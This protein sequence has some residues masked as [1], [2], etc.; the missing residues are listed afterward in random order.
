MPRKERTVPQPGA[1]LASARNYTTNRSAE[2]IDR[3]RGRTAEEW[4]H[5]AWDFFD[6][7][8]EYHQ[9]CMAIGALLS[10][11]KLVVEERDADG[12]WR[13]TENAAVLQVHNELYGG[14]E[15]QAEMLR[16]F[17][18]HFAVTG[19]GWLIAESNATTPDQWMVASP[20]AVRKGAGNAWRVNDEDLTGTPLVIRIWRAHS[21][22]RK[23]A[24][25]PTRA[26]LP[27]L[28]ELL[29][30]TKRVAAQIDSRLLGG[31][32][33]LLP[34][35]TSFGVA[36]QKALNVGDPVTGGTDSIA[37]GDAQ[38]LAD[39][40]VEQANRA[41]ANPEDP[42][43]V[44]PIIGETPGEFIDKAR[45]LT[46]WSELDKTAPK[47]RAESIQRIAN[48]MDIPPEVLLGAQGSN[49]WNAWLSD[50]VSVKIHAEPTL[51]TIVTSLSSGYLRPALT[52][53]VD[54]PTRF[55]YAAD[56][57]Q[58][59][60]RPNRSKEAL[61]LNDRLILSDA[62][63]ARENGFEPADLMTDE[64]K[65]QK[66]IGLAA[67]GSTTP[68]IVAAAMK[69]LG[70]DLGIQITDQR[71]PAQARPNRSLDEHPVREIPAA[72]TGNSPDSGTGRGDTGNKQLPA[73]ANAAALGLLF[74]SEQIVDR[75]LQ[76]AG[77]R[78]KTQM[79][80]QQRKEV[81][82][83]ANRLYCSAHI[84]PEDVPDLLSDA[85]GACHEYDYGVSGAALERVLSLYTRSLLTSGAEPT[86]RGLA[87][88]LSLLP[89][90]PGA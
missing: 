73:A 80:L 30:L 57:A 15:G 1:I 87:V 45:H 49:H 70:I 40:L 66:V 88:A 78:L 38:G 26:I 82:T 31:G 32:L 72:P 60:L 79:P 10:R 85:W 8:P 81:T 25:S 16:Q 27:V 76:R 90:L 75:A 55:R 17:G 20:I 56:T 64:E 54:D 36:P 74:A 48:G 35:E 65:A 21:L 2:K 42:S 9:G 63:T 86:R 13:P 77:N 29:Q 41:I 44:F 33:L 89:E 34:S 69:R 84:L 71:D 6:M 18:I 19:E 67:R 46:F 61:E 83:P 7:I 3:Q 24:D 12:T 28:S 50:E 39:M 11:A 5:A 47:L 23:K 43:A 22:D 14:E 62:A 37:A 59:R 4:M 51:K 53:I 58:M 52:G 68:E